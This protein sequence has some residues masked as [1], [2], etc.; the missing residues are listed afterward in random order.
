MQKLQHRESE[1]GYRVAR[2]TRVSRVVVGM[3]LG[4]GH[5]HSEP[6]VG[7]GATPSI[8]AEPM[9]CTLLQPQ[10][11]RD[12]RG[13]L[14]DSFSPTD[15]CPLSP[16]ELDRCIRDCYA[17]L[18][19]QENMDC[20]GDCQSVREIPI[21]WSRPPS[22]RISVLVRAPPAEGEYAVEGI[23]A[24]VEDCTGTRQCQPHVLVAE[25]LAHE[26]LPQGGFGYLP[27]KDEPFIKVMDPKPQCWS[28]GQQVR[29]YVS[30]VRPGE[31]RR[32][33]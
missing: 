32:T 11:A 23:I 1:R 21:S 13:C 18:Q 24:K 10:A 5:S 33:P 6:K 28:F 26:N 7:A 16:A 20:E 30:V 9:A 25:Y 12:A 22:F 4:C 17:M 19:E 3:A 29:W 8:L 14:G 31:Y 2:L 27:Q 15:G